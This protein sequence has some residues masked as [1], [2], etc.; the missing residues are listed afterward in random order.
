MIPEVRNLF[1][2]P[3]P[4]TEGEVFRKLLEGGSF[5][6]EAITSRGAASPEGSWYDQPHPEWVL[7]V[8]GSASLEFDADEKVDLVSGD[9]LLI[10]A[11]CR[12]RVSSVSSDALW[13]ALH[14]GESALRGRQE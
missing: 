7:L 3:L 10:P 5:R 14:E 13:L 9:H 12:H 11:R 6:L 1:T 4:E 2:A 8:R